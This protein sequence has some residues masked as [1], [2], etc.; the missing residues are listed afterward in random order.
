MCQNAHLPGGDEL[1][2]S[3]GQSVGK[4]PKWHPGGQGDPQQFLIG[5]L[6]TRHIKDVKVAVGSQSEVGTMLAT[7]EPQVFAHLPKLTRSGSANLD[8][9]ASDLGTA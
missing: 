1:N 7:R 4:L 3:P 2:W 8:G 6:K 9:F 5:C